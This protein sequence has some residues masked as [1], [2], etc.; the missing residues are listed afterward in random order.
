[1]SQEIKIRYRD[2]EDAVSKIENAADAFETTLVKDLASGNELDVVT[3]LNEINNLLEDIG[4]TYNSVL[5]DNNQ[6]V[7][8]TLQDLKEVDQN[9]SS[10]IKSR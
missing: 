8:K 4:R 1:M 5:K 3:K 2:V 6:S 9:I 7:L 10:S